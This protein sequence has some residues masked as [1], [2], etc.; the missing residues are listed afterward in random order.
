MP[1]HP[2]HSPFYLRSEERPL[3]IDEGVDYSSW[4]QGGSGSAP[5]AWHPDGV[6]VFLPPDA[7]ASMDEYADAEIYRVDENIGGAFHQG[8]L[9]CA[10]R[11]IGRALGDQPPRSGEPPS[12]LDVGCGEGELL[13]HIL[14]QRPDLKTVTG[15]DVSLTAVLAAKKRL[16]DGVF[17]A[18]DANALPFAPESFDIVTCLNLLEHVE[19]PVRLLREVYR[20]L[21]PGGHVIL[22]TP[23]RWRVENLVRA[24]RGQSPSFM[25]VSHV[26][27]YSVGQVEEFLRWSGLMLRAV[28]SPSISAQTGRLPKR[29][30][31]PALKS[32]VRAVGSK[33]V[34]EPTAFFW[35]QK[36]E[37]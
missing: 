14:S 19:S 36:P 2:D 16:P 5:Y 12:L 8:R 26:T 27:E 3:M 32:V 30:L 17:C 6:G 20:A 22:S 33:H 29:L 13:L 21:R 28:D 9:T 1:G 31:L 18:G 7:I 23:S 24:L 10:S 25:S 15:M 37:T 11:L 34:L 4:R 35:A